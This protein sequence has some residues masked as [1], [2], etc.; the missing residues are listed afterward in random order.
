MYSKNSSFPHVPNL[1][2]LVFGTYE[3]EKAYK[4]YVRL[5][6]K[7]HKDDFN[8]ALERALP[9]VGM[10]IK[11]FFPD[12][13][14]RGEE[15][16]LIAEG[17]CVIVERLKKKTFKGD[18]DASYQAYLLAYLKGSMLGTLDRTA[19][20]IFD[21]RFAGKDIP[22][23]R[24]DEARDTEFRIFLSELPDSIVEEVI[25]NCRFTGKEKKIVSHIVKRVVRGRRVVPKLIESY[26]EVTNSKLYIDYVSIKIRNYLYSIRG[27][28]NETSLMTSWHDVA[29]YYIPEAGLHA[30]EQML[31]SLWT[32]V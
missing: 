7:Y 29:D 26:F 6:K 5:T 11:I 13:G 10:A 19:T 12:I 23:G 20:K 4:A 25:T 32:A 30:E 17:V 15:D 18:T 9:L 21:F 1:K 28:L 2:A 16:E 8:R 22:V 14:G 3:R 27:S 24:V 31:E